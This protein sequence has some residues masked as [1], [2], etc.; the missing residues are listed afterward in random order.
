[1]C[2]ATA[3]EKLKLLLSMI[4]NPMGKKRRFID[5]YYWNSTAW[6]QLSIWNDYLCKIGLANADCKIAIFTDVLQARF[7]LSKLCIFD[8]SGA[9]SEIT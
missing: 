2:Y 6:T 9:T 1:M 8:S 4:I 3:H 5:N 7:K